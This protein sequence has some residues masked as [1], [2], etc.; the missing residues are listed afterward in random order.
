MRH[1]KTEKRIVKA[2]KVYKNRLIAIFI[3]KIMRDGKKTT[4]EKVF[5]DSLEK[6]KKQQKNPVDVFELAIQNVGP[7][8]EVKPRRVGG[9]SYQVPAEVRGD[10]RVSLA[11]RW[12]I[13]AAKARSSKD[14]RGF[15]EK[16]AAEFL[17]ASQN[18]GA[19]IKKRD[20]VQK[21]AEANKAFA[22][23]RW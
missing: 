9:A 17:D 20:V 11:M 2:D 5:Y 15:S 12:I 14:Y 10:R 23:F 16:L 4:A 22:H 21:Q 8:I 3:N 13:A 7:K 19:A 6:I 18:L 1:K